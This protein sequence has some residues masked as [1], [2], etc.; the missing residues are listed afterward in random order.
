MPVET[1]TLEEFDTLR[2]QGDTYLLLTDIEAT[3]RA[4][5][6]ARAALKNL[7]GDELAALRSY[8]ADDAALV[9]N[10]VVY[11]ADGSGQGG[12]GSWLAYDGIELEVKT[13]QGTAFFAYLQRV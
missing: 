1:L 6:M 3:R 5:S 4:E 8:S 10:L 9:A 12:R 11:G 7:D 2:A 13:R